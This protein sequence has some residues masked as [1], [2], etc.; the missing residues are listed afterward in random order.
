MKAKIL[1]ISLTIIVGAIG[2]M[3]GRNTDKGSDKNNQISAGGSSAMRS[4][5]GSNLSSSSDVRRSSATA[6]TGTDIASSMDKTKT[7]PVARMRALSEINDPLERARLWLQLVDSLSPDQFQDFVAAFRADGIPSERMGDYS[8]LLSAW[9]KVNPQEA[10][11]YASKATNNPFARQTIL[12]SWAGYDPDS[13][14]SWAK[15]NH[16]GEGANPWMVGVIK[17]LAFQDPDRAS[18]LL[19]EMPRS[20]ERGEAL[21]NLLPALLKRGIAE[22]RDWVDSITD[23][24]LKEG[25]ISRVA[26][27][28]AAKDPQGT[29]DWLVANPSEAANR[30]IDDALYAMANKDQSA[31]LDYFSKLPSGEAR[32][33]ALR[34]II[35]AVASDD[36]QKASAL[37]DSHSGDLTDRAVQQFVW[38]SFRQDPQTAVANISRMTN[39]EEQERMYTRTIEWWMERDQQAALN[40]VN[41]NTLPPN[42]VDR[43]NRNLQREQQRSN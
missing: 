43:L 38:H 2:F 32:S 25:A 3:V 35:N 12:A 19:M 36:P 27:S 4:S 8:M 21:D 22:T 5:S 28:T 39:P 10:L 30:R 33:N 37:M 17:G 14:I 34:G 18:S 11:D 42:V 7:D 40:W 15:S 20:Q 16:T 6:R 13:A 1:P 26:E 41:G 9:A 29:A 24:A 23:P 31:A